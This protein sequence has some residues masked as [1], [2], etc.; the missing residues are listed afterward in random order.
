[1]IHQL[2]QAG[3]SLLAVLLECQ[4]FINRAQD[5]GDGGETLFRAL[6]P[7]SV[8]ALRSC[9][10]LLRR[11]SGR[12]VCG[13]RSADLI[14]EC[15]RRTR[16][17][18]EVGA[19]PGGAPESVLA[20]SRRPWLRPVRRKTVS[21]TG[22]TPV[23][24]MEE[25]SSQSTASQSP[26]GHHPSDTPPPL[27]PHPP[28]MPTQQTMDALAGLPLPGPVASPGPFL[29]GAEGVNGAI[30]MPGSGMDV[31]EYG[32]LDGGMG[33]DMSTLDFMALLNYDASGA[34]P[35]PFYPPPPPQQQRQGMPGGMMR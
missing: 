20:R 33:V 24:N 28:A 5:D 3:R 6:I 35:G 26:E 29:M 27:P 4:H 7:P 1:M 12:Y 30:P 9:L 11:F 14:E 31:L 19:A 23:R 8:D 21:S 13:L 2:T 16:I 15:C 18:L 32:A 22:G 17:P 25:D 10:G 34:P